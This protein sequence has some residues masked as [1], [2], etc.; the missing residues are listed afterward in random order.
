M[1]TE[2]V[3]VSV[4]LSKTVGETAGDVGERGRIHSMALEMSS[5]KFDVLKSN[6][7]T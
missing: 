4:S 2:P 1:A 6:P 5:C 7:L 3:S